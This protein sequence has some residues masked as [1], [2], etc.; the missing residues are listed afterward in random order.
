MFCGI[1]VGVI[2]IL[3]SYKNSD[4]TD[5]LLLNNFIT[6]SKILS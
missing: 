6:L 2:I 1:L 4:K 5:K 3:I